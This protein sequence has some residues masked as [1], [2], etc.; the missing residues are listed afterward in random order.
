MERAERIFVTLIACMAVF[1]VV[2]F[3]MQLART[4]YSL[5]QNEGRRK[6]GAVYMTL[7][8]PFYNAIDDEIRARVESRGDVLLSRDPALNQKLQNEEINDLIASGVSLI[9]VTPV[10]KRDIA[11]A[12]RAAKAAGVPIIAVDTDVEDASLVAATVTSDNYLAGKLCAEHMI[13]N[14]PGG[15]IILLKHSDAQSAAER[16]RGFSDAMMG[17]DEFTVVAERECF[18]QLEL[19]M[20]VMENILAE[21]TDIDAV[22]AINDPSALGAAAALSSAGILARVSV[23]GI[24][25]TKEVRD[26]IL[27][28][29]MTATVRQQ[30][31]A[32][33]S[34]AAETA[35][36][37]LDGEKVP[38]EIRL[39]TTLL[40]QETLLDENDEDG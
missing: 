29:S 3:L 27:A 28:G 33:G 26:M 21:T 17:H 13:N 9:F 22:F 31:T 4:D 12:L 7:N 15:N 30:P 20:P 19:A 23:Y 2:L 11:P 14:L 6:F 5:R 24:D 18:G 39:P 10:D 8:N 16:M 38:R 36:R 37:L 34:I 35:Y 1:L 25:G 40:T 32:M